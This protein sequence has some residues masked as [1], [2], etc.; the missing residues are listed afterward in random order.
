MVKVEDLEINQTCLLGNNAHG[1]LVKKME[2]SQNEVGANGCFVLHFE[3][4]DK[5]QTVICGW[6][7]EV[8]IL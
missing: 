5:I 8:E 2:F 6:N 1:K 3:I 4:D 7:D